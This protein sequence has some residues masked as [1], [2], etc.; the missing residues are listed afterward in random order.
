MATTKYEEDA[1]AVAKAINTF[2]KTFGLR[3]FPGEMFCIDKQASY[4]ND[5]GVVMLYT[6]VKRDGGK[7]LSF[8]KGTAE[9]LR[10]EVTA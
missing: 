8:A 10:A 4:V 1:N 2:P 3:A 9:E 6:A 7:W 5:E